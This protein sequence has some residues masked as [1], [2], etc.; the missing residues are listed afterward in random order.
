MRRMIS[1]PFSSSN[2]LWA[3]Y[4]IVSSTRPIVTHRFS[5]PS[6][7]SS[8]NETAS[9]SSKTH[10]A[11]QKLKPC[12]TSFDWFLSSSHSN[13]KSEPT[14]VHS[15]SSN[16]KNVVYTTCRESQTLGPNRLGFKR[17]RQE[18]PHLWAGRHSMVGAVSPFVARIRA[19]P[20]GPSVVST[21]KTRRST[22]CFRGGRG[23]SWIAKRTEGRTAVRVKLLQTRSR[24]TSERK[25][26]S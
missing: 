6:N 20:F 19:G 11:S 24:G 26:L 5:T 12:L 25:R 18:H 8:R 3:T 1:S 9:R 4:T 17:K 23:F 15:S 14:L 13:C 7:R 10:A 16:Y 22:H 21:R 2:T